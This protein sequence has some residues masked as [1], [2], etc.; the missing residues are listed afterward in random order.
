[1]LLGGPEEL[2]NAGGGVG[3]Q[4]RRLVP[5]GRLGLAVALLS[6]RLVA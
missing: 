4:G 6:A 3:V 2:L 5:G 1:L